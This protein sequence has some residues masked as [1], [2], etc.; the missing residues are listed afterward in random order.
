MLADLE[1]A[2]LAGVVE[3]ED[4][5]DLGEDGGGDAL[6]DAAQGGFRVVGHHQDADT[7]HERSLSL[8]CGHLGMRGRPVGGHACHRTLYS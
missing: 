3:D 5:L 7:C 1:G 2:V 6:E 8:G 4:L